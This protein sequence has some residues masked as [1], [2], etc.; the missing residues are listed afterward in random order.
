MKNIPTIQ[1][2]PSQP[3]KLA[4]LRQAHQEWVSAPDVL[5]RLTR[6]LST[7]LVLETQLGILA[8][9][10]GQIIPFDSMNYR[11]RIN[12][13]DFVFSTGMGGPHRCEYRLNLEGTCYG[14]LTLN[15]RQRFSE[16][17]LQGVETIISVAICPLRNACQYLGIEQA[18]LTDALT[19]VANKRALDEDLARSKQLAERHRQQYSLILCDLDHFKAVNDNHGHVVGDHLLQMAAEAMERSLRTSDTIY[20]FGGEEFAVLLPLTG[21]KDARDVAERL[22]IA[23]GKICIDCGDTTLSV[24][25]SCGVATHLYGETTEQWLARADEA[26]YQAKHLG[27]NCTRV[28]ASIG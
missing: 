9:E 4:A 16:E 25:T 27:R 7:T 21:E 1:R 28:F 20:R 18:A 19:G 12:R 23:I 26:L 10:L 17:E 2:S 5:T 15:R 11:H 13:Q 24:T 8:E 14:T 6:R 22:R 3:Q